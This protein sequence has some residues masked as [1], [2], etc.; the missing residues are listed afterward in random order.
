MTHLYEAMRWTVDEPGQPREYVVH[1]GGE[2]LAN[3]RRV[4]VARPGDAA[5]P[6]ANPHAAYDETR[7]VVCA[8]G[9]DGT[10][11]FYVD[12]TPHANGSA[13][14][15]VVAPNG[16]FIGSVCVGKVGLGGVFKLLSGQGGS[17]FDLRDASGTILATMTSP[18]RSNHGGTVTD[19][20]GTPVAWRSVA[21]SPHVRRRRQHTMRIDRRH[22]EPLHTLLLAA[23]IGVELMTPLL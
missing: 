9:P 11:Y 22:P 2:I 6:Y 12:R 15:L 17:G 3:V 5:M 4:A 13:P 19:P 23:L 21:V 7:I 18:T 16:A 20:H 8:A 14:A 1:D 10:P